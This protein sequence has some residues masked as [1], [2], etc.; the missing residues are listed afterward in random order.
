MTAVRA[1]LPPMP[2][3]IASLPVDERGYPIPW[4][5]S[6]ID[7]RPDFRVV[8]PERQ[9]EA[10]Q[11]GRCWICGGWLGSRRAFAIGPMCAVNRTSGEPPSHVDCADW[12]ARACP[13][14]TRPHMR[15]RDDHIPDGA[16]MHEAALSRNP[17]VVLVWVTK[18][19]RAKPTPQS[20]LFDVGEP[21]ETRWYAE[22]RPAT[23]D[24]II[25]SIESGFP[26]LHAMAAAEGPRAIAHLNQQLVAALLLL[27]GAS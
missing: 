17:G 21:L 2:E 12:A 24:E 11:Y 15:R 25:D 22:G 23:R 27:P 13:F 5:V 16:T 1:E 26:K 6:W 10:H 20:L 9:V 14:L 3:R 7:G 19:Y 4:F 8:A 18:R